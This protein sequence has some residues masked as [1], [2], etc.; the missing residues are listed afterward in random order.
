V[1]QGTE[2]SYINLAWEIDGFYSDSS[3]VM[4]VFLRAPDGRF[5]TF[6]APGAGT[7]PGQGTSGTTIDQSG[8]VN[9]LR[10]P[11]VV[12]ALKVL[13]KIEEVV[14]SQIYRF[15]VDWLNTNDGDANGSS[16]S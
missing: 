6:E 7:S 5:T 3:S 16:V 11:A 8:Q 4:H 9:D 2:T 15:L 12:F 1:G 13:R 10:F 14:C